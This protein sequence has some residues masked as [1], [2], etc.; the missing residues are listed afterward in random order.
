M[1]LV[2]ISFPFGTKK[3]TDLINEQRG[4]LPFSNAANTW[5]EKKLI[6]IMREELD[7]KPGVMLRNRIYLI[8]GLPWALVSLTQP[9]DR[10]KFPKIS[11]R[12]IKTLYRIASGSD[13]EKILCNQGKKNFKGSDI[14]RVCNT[15]TANNL[16]AGLEILK[17]IIQELKVEKQKKLLFFFRDSQFAWPLGYLK[18]K[19]E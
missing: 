8:G 13:A 3:A 14:E 4:D 15:F 12:H 1:K 19:I 17:G 18:S 5:R 6:P 10:N 2:P 11:I 16:V 9:M 7:R